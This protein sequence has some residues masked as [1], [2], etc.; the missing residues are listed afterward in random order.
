M[1]EYMREYRAAQQ[2]LL[3][4]ARLQLGIN[5]KIRTQKKRRKKK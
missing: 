1:A 3:K 4:Q 5:T 2:R